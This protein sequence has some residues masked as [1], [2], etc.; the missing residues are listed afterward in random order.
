MRVMIGARHSG[1]TV[2]LA[3][4]TSSGSGTEKVFIEFLLMVFA[5]AN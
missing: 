2:S 4:S 1:L 3:A 5:L